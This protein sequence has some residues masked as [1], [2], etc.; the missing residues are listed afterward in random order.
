MVQ[1]EYAF[2]NLKKSTH[3][4]KA[5]GGEKYYYD[6]NLNEILTP[7]KG[8]IKEWHYRRHNPQGESIEHYNAKM[9]VLNDGFIIVNDFKI[10]PNLIITEFFIKEINK[11]PDLVF[12]DENKNIICV[13]EICHTNGK[14]LKDIEIYKKNNIVCYERDTYFEGFRELTITERVR[15]FRIKFKELK[16]LREENNSTTSRIKK[17]ESEEFDTTKPIKFIP[18]TEEEQSNNILEIEEIKKHIDET[19]KFIAYQKNRSRQAYTICK[20]NF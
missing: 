14:D 3:I 4:S 2:S 9:K 7:V 19:K 10:K 5:I 6:K 1:I 12:F 16:K 18:E 15:E 11:R 13:V 20:R 8:G 17:I